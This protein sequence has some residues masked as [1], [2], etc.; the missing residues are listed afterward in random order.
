M[1]EFRV[2]FPQRLTAAEAVPA[3]AP[4]PPLRAK[5]APASP[6][7]PAA[8]PAPVPVPVDPW[9]T[10][11][12]R[13]V[14]EEEGQIR[15]AMAALR[16]AADEA[17]KQQAGRIDE[18][19]RLAV[20][21]AL[22]IAT[23]LMHEHVTRDE[24][25]VEAM[26]RDMADQLVDDV[27]ASVRLNPADLELLERRLGGEPLLPGADDPRLIPDPAVGRG[28]CRVDGA[29]GAMLVTDPGRM[30]QEIRDDLLARM[31]HAGP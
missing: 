10:E 11:V 12:G 19:Q 15:A 9:Q 1:R 8:Q 3:D 14:R 26:V 22:T 25:P 4:L 6:P 24:F 2:V 5:A 7:P 27:P 18:W 28:G 16:A 20:E 30:L 31:G 17:R 29:S 23:R 21:L 13:Q